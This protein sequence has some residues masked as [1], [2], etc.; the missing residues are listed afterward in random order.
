MTDAVLDVAIKRAV[1]A[2]AV[3]VDRAGRR[4][5]RLGRAR[6][7]R[8]ARARPHAAARSRARRRRPAARL[9]E[10]YQRILIDEFQDTDPIQVEL[11]ALLGSDDPDRRRPAVGRDER[12]PRPPVLRRRSQAVDLPLPPGRHRHVP[13]GRGTV[14]RAA[15]RCSS[16]AT[17][18]P[19]RRCSAWINHVFGELIQPYAGVAARV[20]R[21]ST[22]PAGAARARPRRRAARR[23][24]PRRPARRRRAAR[25]RGG[26]RRRDRA[27]RGRRGVAGLRQGARRV[28]AGP[29]RRH[30]HPA[31]RRARR[32]ATSSRRSTRPASR[33]APRR[34]R[35]ST[36]A[37]RS[38]T[39]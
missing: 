23:R 7:P 26:R 27:R 32:S 39:C 1:A 17:S 8:P 20:P 36:A 34:A 29:A 24:A 13:R 2:I 15:R 33:T 6:L 4:A 5:A 14:R 9:R 18:A 30:L 11:A 12:R 22:R 38:A 3:Y 25:A 21:R 10:R 28:A 37:A 16:R 35:S 31:A 19:R